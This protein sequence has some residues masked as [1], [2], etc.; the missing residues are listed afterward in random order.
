MKTTHMKTKRGS[1]FRTHYG[2]DVSHHYQLGRDSEDADQWESFRVENRKCFRGCCH[3][4]AGGGP[5]RH[6]SSYVVGL[7]SISGFLSL[8]LSW[9]RG[10]KIRK[11]LVTDQHL[12][13]LGQLWFGSPGWLLS[14]FVGQ[15][16]V[17][18]YG[19]AMVHLRT[20]SFN[21]VYLRYVTA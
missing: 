13:V 15:S 4:A 6:R 16:S 7:G 11:A 19:L 2:K 10:Q 9:K 18:T 3:G 12:T 5:A 14:E 17:V 1:S 21:V 20:Q 8:F